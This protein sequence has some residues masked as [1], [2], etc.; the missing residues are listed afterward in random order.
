MVFDN[1]TNTHCNPPDSVIIFDN[2]KPK[3]YANLKDL[4]A[5]PD[6]WPGGKPISFRALSDLTE[7]TTGHRVSYSTLSNIANGHSAGNIRTF[8]LVAQAAG[9]S[10]CHFFTTDPGDCNPAPPTDDPDEATPL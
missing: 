10:W 5:D 8:E 1:E 6:L 7:Q 3:K 2:M 4:M 9:I